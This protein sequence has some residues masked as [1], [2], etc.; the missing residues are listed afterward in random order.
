[1]FGAGIDQLCV[2]LVGGNLTFY[3]IEWTVQMQL[4]ATL[5]SMIGAL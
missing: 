2:G 4:D 1:M 5:H 3:L